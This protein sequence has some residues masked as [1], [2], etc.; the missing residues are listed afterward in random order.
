MKTD[1]NDFYSIIIVG[2][3]RMQIFDQLTFLV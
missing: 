1:A 3:G 2:D